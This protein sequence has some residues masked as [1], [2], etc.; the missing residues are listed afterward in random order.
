MKEYPH[1]IRRVLCLML[2]VVGILMTSGAA[3]CESDF[4]QAA[5]GPVGDGVKQI[6]NGL[7]DGV[8]A[9]VKNAGDGP[10]VE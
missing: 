5:I 8:I 4:R 1:R 7:L 6:A 2:A 10:A 3:D 9:A